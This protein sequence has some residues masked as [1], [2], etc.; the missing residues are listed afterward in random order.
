MATPEVAGLAALLWATGMHN[1]AQIRQRLMDTA[2]DLGAPGWDPQ[3][4]AGRINAYRAITGRAPTRRRWCSRGAGTRGTK[5]VPVQF[6]GSASSDPN[7]KAITFAGTSAI[8]LGVEHVDA[9]APTH[10]Y[11]RAGT[12]TVTLTVND[13][14]NRTT[15]AT[16]QAVIRTS[17]RP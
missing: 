4:G 11:L 1:A 14:S 8:P 12:Y 7:G 13:A 5:G 2:D 16:T 15:T 9:A 10:T 6:D 17:R 3:T